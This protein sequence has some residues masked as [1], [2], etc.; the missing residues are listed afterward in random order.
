M[1]VRKRI[2]GTAR[3]DCRTSQRKGSV[4]TP[5]ATGVTELTA[6]TWLPKLIAAIKREYPKAIVEAEVKLSSVL[7]ERLAE[8]SI[9]FIV[10]PGAALSEAYVSRHL[11]SVPNS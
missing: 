2:A 9:D 5:A 10:V 3:R 1:C 6:L 7:P 11:A 8:D 4:G